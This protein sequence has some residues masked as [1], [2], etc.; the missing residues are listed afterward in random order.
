MEQLI[1][2]LVFGFAL[3]ISVLFLIIA[4]ATYYWNKLP[5]NVRV[6][7]GRLYIVIVIPWIAWFGLRFL[8]ALKRDRRIE[9][10][11]V[12]LWLVPIGLLI[13]FTVV[14]WVLAGFR[15][16]DHFSSEA[17]EKTNRVSRF[18][19]TA[20]L[21]A[22][23]FRVEQDAKQ[24]ADRPV[25][26]LSSKGQSKD[27]ALKVIRN[28]TN[29][30][31]IIAG[32]QAAVFAGLLVSFLT[33]DQPYSEFPPMLIAYLGVTALIYAGLSLMLRHYY[34][35]VF[36]IILVLLSVATALSSLIAGSGG[37]ARGNVVVSLITIWASGRA[38]IAAFKLHR[39]AA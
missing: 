17:A 16:S 20:A 27:D 29:V 5:D 21:E 31:L 12:P 3:P 36:A 13:I 24:G 9:E 33:P 30:L 28:S 1:K 8:N 7:L 19:Q 11:L 35:R 32:I 22:S 37:A 23:I 6:G 18:D 25:H 14:S 10:E 38:A 15:R 26:T 34:S 39:V 2:L 4:V